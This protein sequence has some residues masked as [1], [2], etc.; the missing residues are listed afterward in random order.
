MWPII[1]M[2]SFHYSGLFHAMQCV[3]VV[4]DVPCRTSSRN[5]G[6]SRVGLFSRWLWHGGASIGGSLAGQ[7]TSTIAPLEAC[8]IT[9][10]WSYGNN[11]PPISESVFLLLPLS[12]L[13]HCNKRFI[14][15]GNIVLRIVS[16]NLGLC[17]LHHLRTYFSF[18]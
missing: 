14:T 17:P 12:C 6:S 7:T 2:N 16:M 9:L 1:H 4:H 8:Q 15:H 3:H 5:R 13:Y 18:P 10:I 11:G